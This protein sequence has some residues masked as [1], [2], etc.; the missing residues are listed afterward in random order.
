MLT[1]LFPYTLDDFSLTCSMI[2][3]SRGV[4]YANICLLAYMI[5]QYV[6]FYKSSGLCVNQCDENSIMSVIEHGGY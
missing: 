2:M 3:Q 6:V 5:Y 1:H 4:F